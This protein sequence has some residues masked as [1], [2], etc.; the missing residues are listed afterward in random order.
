MADLSFFSL[1]IFIFLSFL[2]ILGLERMLFFTD[3]VGFLMGLA[4]M[5]LE[6]TDFLLRDDGFFAFLADFVA[7]LRGAVGMLM[8][9]L[10]CLGSFYF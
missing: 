1:G 7:G 4:L 10:L 2:A 6:L 9:K 5:D 8:A 3:L